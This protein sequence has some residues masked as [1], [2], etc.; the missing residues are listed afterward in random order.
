MGLITETNYQYYEGSQIFVSTGNTN[1]VL[2]CTF[3]SQLE[4]HERPPDI[5]TKIS[6]T[7][8]GNNFVIGDVL[9]A[10]G[11]IS[12]GEL[13][14]TGEGLT[15][16]IIQVGG[17]GG[18]ASLGQDGADGWT[19]ISDGSG[20]KVGDRIFVQ[21][22]GQLNTVITKI[23]QGNSYFAGDIINVSGGSG[24]GMVIRVDTVTPVQGGPS[25]TILTWTIIDQGSGYAAGDIIFMP[26][27][28]PGAG[29]AQFEIV[30]VP[31]PNPNYM[32]AF[33]IVD[34]I[35]ASSNAN[36]VI[37]VRGANDNDYVLYQGNY[38]LSGNNQIT[39]PAPIAAG[40]SIKVRVIDNVK[41]NNYGGY[42]YVP[43][44]E[45]VSNF[46]NVYVGSGN[47]IANARRSDVIFHAKRA[48]QEFSYDTLKSVKSQELTIPHSL[49]VVIPQDYVNYVQLSWVD[50][51]GVKHIIYPA[52]KLTSNPL[53][54]VQD[55]TGLPAQGNY[56]Q[57]LE[58]A[59][60][61]TTER[62]KNANDK[63]LTGE[64]FIDEEPFVYG[65][66]WWKL[67][68]GQRYGIDPQLSQKNGWF[69][70][71]ERKGTFCFSS[72]L[73]N[74]LIILDYISDGLAYDVDTKVPKMAEEAM[75]TQII[76]SILSVRANVPEYIINR[77]RREKSS[78]LR[79]AKIRLS[80]IK[81]EAFTQVMRGKSKWIKH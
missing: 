81:L 42:E 30:S 4:D 47:I 20:Y 72:N 40:T 12:A 55:S 19:I 68:Y 5:Q 2:Q 9:S 38:Y 26:H 27:T 75:Y 66:D 62:W 50:Q 21:N 54:V 51:L 3:D 33:F 39:I 8:S 71:D 23:Q 76:Y 60:S 31:G 17:N 35:P 48:L 67:F 14:S 25:G 45:I 79:N 11:F 16:E 41:W 80:N 6:L 36:Y 10:V 24:N 57:N 44:S 65:F 78:K 15:L 1:Q 70:I 64:M 34:E 53:P 22:P 52:N 59:Q 18:I 32:N 69:T 56:G 28:P 77:Y 63:Q 73:H 46:M 29:V 13:T 37:E 58:Y 74:K 49:S 43:L 7:N 61:L